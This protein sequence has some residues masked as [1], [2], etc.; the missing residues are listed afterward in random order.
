MEKEQEREWAEAQKIVVSTDLIT[1]A[2]NQLKFLAA[3]DRNRYLYEGLALEWAIYRYNAYWLP[4]LAKH[5]EK[6]VSDEPLVVPLDC[7]WIWHCHRLSPVRYKYDCEKLF[8]RVL[9]NHNIISSFHGTS[10]SKTEKI[11][12]SMYPEEPYELDHNRHFSDISQKSVQSENFTSYDLVSAVKRQVSFCY[13]VSRPHVSDDVFLQEALTRYKGFLHLIRTNKKK[14]IK[15]LCV[16]T[17]DVDLMWHSHQL[18]PVSYCNDLIKLIGQVLDHDDTDSDRTK[19][20]K[21]DTNF[22]GTTSQWEE[23]FGF[24]YWKAG[25]MYRGTTPTPVA[26]LPF[27]FIYEGKKSYAPNSYDNLIPL[28]KKKTVEVLLEFIE[29]KNLPEDHKG[30]L[31]VSFSKKQPDMLF[32]PKRTMTI[33]SES[34]EKQVAF[35][36]CEPTGEFLFEV[37]QHSPSN[38]S[39]P[40]SFKLIGSCSLSFQERLASG[41][42]YSANKWLP[43]VPM[44]G[45]LVS[46][47]ILLHVSLSCTP[48][49]PAPHVFHLLESHSFFK[50]SGF[51]PLPKVGNIKHVNGQ[52]LVI[53]HDGNDV[54]NLKLRDFSKDITRSTHGLLKEVLYIT[55]S[56][57]THTLAE[58][59]GNEWVIK[60]S[61]GS[62]KLHYTS[63]N[64]GHIFDLIGNKMVRIFVGRKLDYEPKHYEKK[65]S[66]KDFITAVEFSAEYPYGRAV[67]LVD[68]NHGI[69]KVMD[70][71]MILTGITLTY[72][73]SDILRREGCFT[74][75]VSCKGNM[76]NQEKNSPYTVGNQV[77][78][79]N[80]NA[81]KAKQG[82]SESGGYENDFDSVCGS[83]D[84]DYGDMVDSGRYG[85]LCVEMAK[86]SGGCG[87]GCGNMANNAR[88][89]SCVVEMPKSDGGCDN[90]CGIMV[91]N[92]GAWCYG[93][94]GG[95]LIKTKDGDDMPKSDGVCDGDC[96]FMINN[97]G[98]ICYGCVGGCLIKTKDG[99]DGD[100]G[101]MVNNG[102][103]MCYG[104]VGG[105]LIKTKDGDDGDC[106]I[107]VNNG[108]AMCYGCVGGCLI[109]TKDGDDGDCG[110]MINNGGA[111]CYGC[112]GGCLI[113]TKDGGD[114]SKY[115][116]NVSAS[117][118]L[119]VKS[120]IVSEP[121]AVA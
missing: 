15:Q 100:C 18:H 114:I 21:L 66:E 45:I 77:V 94:V 105:C 36:Q 40:E 9:G 13:Q 2:K 39:L 120:S 69:L 48:P 20:K 6:P 112:V 80:T 92:G 50:G 52:T 70:E 8:G 43:V 63:E 62:W 58:L 30:N 101:I 102:G 26:Q 116:D 55:N 78:L 67:A 42:P 53:D 3:V 119:V 33:L 19:G 109:K 107:M 12:N 82:L 23:T 31:C 68:L 110:I 17:Y 65:R 73:L 10:K 5:L 97:G 32:S 106:G 99:D 91:N 44:P 37:M 56:S 28:Q 72:I 11:W 4:L 95:C 93:C 74:A 41:S 49:T 75:K 118:M 71:W 87:S 7:E 113:K 108:G 103:A 61:H 22:S 60:G 84:G 54:L 34:G 29:I 90:D 27:P 85:A 104:C 89:G 117:D 25:A 81:L 38:M 47:P 96:G 86:C 16:P 57:E 59:Q 1:A 115:H 24:S 79:A 83:C 88:S 76:L 46:E 51:I 121:M 98:A 35:F 64:D 111:M 14:N